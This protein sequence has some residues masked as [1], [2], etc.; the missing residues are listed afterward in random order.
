MGD[1]PLQTWHMDQLCEYKPKHDKIPKAAWLRSRDIVI[2]LL[3]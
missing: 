1:Y 2:P 3:S